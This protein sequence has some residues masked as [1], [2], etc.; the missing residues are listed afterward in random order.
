[1]YTEIDYE[2]FED[3]GAAYQRSEK[4]FADF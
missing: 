4:S 2:N 1:M 3:D